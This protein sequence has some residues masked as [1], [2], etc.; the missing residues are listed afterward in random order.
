M[1]S[2]RDLVSVSPFVHF[3]FAFPGVTGGRVAMTAAWTPLSP[4]YSGRRRQ[5]AWQSFQQLLSQPMSAAASSPV[6]V[7]LSV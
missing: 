6:E 1:V 3:G 5:M 4:K 2:L 7:F